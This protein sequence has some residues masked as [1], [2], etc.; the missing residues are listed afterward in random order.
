MASVSLRCSV[1]SCTNSSDKISP[2]KNLELAVSA[3]VVDFLAALD[4]P[5]LSGRLDFVFIIIL[6]AGCAHSNSG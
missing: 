2:A 3:F 6:Y 5:D 4:L 1:I